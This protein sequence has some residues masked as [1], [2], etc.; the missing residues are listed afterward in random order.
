MKHIITVL[1][2][3]FSLGACSE[4]QK[5]YKSG[6][7]SER[8]ELGESLYNEGKYKKARRLFEQI[9]PGYRGK[10]GAEKLMYMYGNTIYNAEDWYEASYQLER[11]VKAYPKSEKVEEFAFKSAK[12]HTYLSP[13]YS[14]DQEDTNKSI[15]K[16]QNFMAQYPDSE[17]FK[18]ASDL[19]IELDEK[20]Q[21]K[22]YEIAKGYHHRISSGTRFK[23]DY[24]A[25][26]TAFDN[27]LRDYPGSKYRDEAMFY[28]FDTAYLL[29]I[30]STDRKKEDRLKDAKVLYNKWKSS[31][32]ESELKKEGETRYE[33]I[34]KELEQV[35]NTN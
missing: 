8:Y 34:N 14:L 18:Q 16:L 19:V 23:D 20:L 12:S 2:I 7:T 26:M 4:Y 25:A 15:M 33:R 9:V 5:I 11:F 28:K 3:A 32:S 21:K 24:K 10:P 17:Y 31:N 22:A 27:F 13:R 30:N 1:F 29:A 6:D 35:N